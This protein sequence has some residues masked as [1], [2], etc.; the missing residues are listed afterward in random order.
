M[1]YTII[2]APNSRDPPNKL[3]DTTSY[4]PLTSSKIKNINGIDTARSADS[5]VWE[6]RGKGWLTLQRRIGRF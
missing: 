1:S 4:Q 6:W 3:D 2:P 5:S